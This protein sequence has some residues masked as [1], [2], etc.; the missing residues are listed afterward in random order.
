VAQG[1]G[2][3][4]KLW[5]RKNKMKQKEQQQKKPGMCVAFFF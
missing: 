5:Y 4:F 2:P 3:E 1:V